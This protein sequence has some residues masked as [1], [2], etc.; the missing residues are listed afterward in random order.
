MTIQGLHTLF[1]VFGIAF[2]AYCCYVL[3]VTFLEAPDKLKIKQNF[4][5]HMVII[6]VG[7]LF[8][9]FKPL[10]LEVQSDNARTQVRHSFDTPVYISDRE[11]VEVSNQSY[12]LSEIRQEKDKS[13]A[14]WDAIRGEE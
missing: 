11:V 7:V 1:Y 14:E 8:L 5:T 2:I 3:A 10:K 12:E 6:A 4:K 13:K 9:L